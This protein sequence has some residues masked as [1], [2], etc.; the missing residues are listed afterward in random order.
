MVQSTIFLFVVKKAKQIF[1][2]KT[3]FHFLHLSIKPFYGGKTFYLGG[4]GH[5][6]FIIQ[7]QV[8]ISEYSSN[9]RDFND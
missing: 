1:F 9:L 5:V 3:A 8:I 2:I 4:T 7:A 6:F